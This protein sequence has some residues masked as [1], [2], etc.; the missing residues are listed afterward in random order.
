MDFWVYIPPIFRPSLSI[1]P[2]SPRFFPDTSAGGGS[3]QE[4]GQA[5]TEAAGGAATHR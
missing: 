4:A 2:P 5:D 1:L 3:D